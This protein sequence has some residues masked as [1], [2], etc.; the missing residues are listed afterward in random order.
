VSLR[1]LEPVLRSYRIVGETITEEPVDL[2]EL[3]SGRLES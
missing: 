2:V 1:D 3:G